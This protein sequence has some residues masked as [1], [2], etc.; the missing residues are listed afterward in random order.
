[1]SSRRACKEVRCH[2]RRQTARDHPRLN[3]SVHRLGAPC[4][5]ARWSGP[6]AARRCHRPC[7]CR[8]GGAGQRRLP[9]GRLAPDPQRAD[10]ACLGQGAVAGVAFAACRWLHAS[11]AQPFRVANADA[12]RNRGS[13]R[14][15]PL[16]TLF[17]LRNKGLPLVQ[18]HRPPRYIAFI[19]IHEPN[20]VHEQT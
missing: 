8:A 16:M 14:K 11:L 20:H 18:K 7:A 9:G 5:R 3:R 15:R 6:V 1:M 13:P 2:R 19:P 12:W 10:L 17:T 4:A